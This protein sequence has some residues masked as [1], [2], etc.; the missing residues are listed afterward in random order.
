MIYL[1]TKNKSFRN[2]E[3][4]LV[5][6]DES[7]QILNRCK[8]LQYDSE[9]TG[10]DTHLDKLLCIQF[11]ND[12]LDVRMVIDCTTIDPLSYKKILESK[13][14]IAHNF[15]FDCQFLYKIGIIPTHVWDTMIVEQMLF[16]GYPYRAKQYNLHAVAMDRLG[17]NI[18]KT[19][20]GQ[21]IWRGLDSEVVKYSAGDVTFLEKIANAQLE[22]CK[23]KNCLVG[24]KLECKFTPVIAYLEWCGIH[25]DVDLWYKKMQEDKNNLDKAKKALD[26]Y[27]VNYYNSHL[28]NF[29][30]FVIPWA[31][32]I[33]EDW[34]NPIDNYPKF[35]YELTKENPYVE[36]EDHITY[37]YKKIKVKFPWVTVPTQLDLFD[38]DNSPKCNINWNS[39]EVIKVFQFF[40]FNTT[41]QDNKTGNNKD[42]IQ[43]KV[44]KGQKG[45]NDEFL[46][47][48]LN[49]QGFAKVCSTYGESYIN[50]INPADNRIHTVFRALGADSGRMACG[51]KQSNLALANAKKIPLSK[52]IN[53][54][55]IQ[56]LPADAETRGAFTSEAGNLMV[57]CDFSALES[58]LGADIYNE[59]AML[60]EYLENS[61]DIHSLTAK[62]VF[63]EEL[64]GIDVKDIKR[65]RPDLRKR[66]KPIEFSQQ[67]GGS[68]HAI[69]NSMGCS[70]EEAKSF[71][72]KYDKGFPGIAEFKRRGSEFV[73][74]HGYIIIN[75]IT[76]HRLNWY[77]WKRWKARQDE[78]DDLYWHEF[79][80]ARKKNPHC[81]M[82]HQAHLDNVEASKY[83]RLALNVVTQGTGSIIIKQ[84]SIDLFDWILQN[85]YFGKIKLCNIVHDKKLIVCRG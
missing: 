60:H 22:D 44:I 34:K 26:D 37:W 12:E 42:S 9:T 72:E 69:M 49:Y 66:A 41:V 71:K 70:L 15:K 10:I 67:F 55:Q 38:P 25:L 1:V 20:R 5:S 63:H 48:Y 53:G 47:L 46:K 74:S 31:F 28:N 81:E 14:L 21:I 7:L 84:A 73:R 17:I 2:S 76:G 80:I 27:I 78:K 8:L 39:Q 65:L 54:V 18:D 19:I 29:K 62:M 83:D 68:A 3:F 30:E 57:D 45:I 23:E 11:G 52:A 6:V 58:R 50:A 40:G 51:S 32:Q 43:E 59:K 35:K 82:V 36:K 16:L 85:N 4:T 24:A 79:A 77:D 64:K 13:T 56:N 61:G 75:P 33:Q